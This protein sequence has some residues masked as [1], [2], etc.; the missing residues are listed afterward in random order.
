MEQDL[1]SPVTGETF[2]MKSECQ[3]GKNWGP[4]KKDKNEEGLQTIVL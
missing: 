4:F 3:V 2:R 1:V